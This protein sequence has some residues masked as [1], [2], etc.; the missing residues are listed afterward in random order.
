MLPTSARAC[1]LGLRGT[2]ILSCPV[3]AQ[4]HSSQ[5]AVINE[6]PAVEGDI[7]VT[8]QKRSERLLDVPLS[9][10]AVSGEA[11]QDRQINSPEQ[12]EQV[13][14]GF[15][16]QKSSF[17]AP[18]FTLRGIGFYNLSA[19]VSPAVSIYLDQ[20]PLAYSAM[21][22]GA[23]LDLERVEVL[24]G[25]QGTLFGQNSTGG[26]INYISAKPTSHPAAGFDLTYGRFNAVE[27]QGYISG[28]ITSTLKARLFARYESRDPWQ[29]GYAPNDLK[30]G[31]NPN[32]ELGRHRF[33]PA[34]CWSIG[35][36]ARPSSFT[37][38]QRAGRIIP[39]VR[40]RSSCNFFRAFRSTC[41]TK[42][43]SMLIRTRRSPCNRCRATL[44]WRDG[45]EV[46]TLRA[47]RASTSSRQIPKLILTSLR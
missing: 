38:P 45:I 11:L 12:L 42:P 35:N 16:Y 6:K 37:S 33:S 46:R 32:D 26:A 34:A 2:T 28:P 20:V 44:A 41:S 1:V 25:P 36:R 15:T 21:A 23:A 3:Q 43:F 5:Q 27:A 17:G 10:T 22:Q 47:G 30:F 29:R 19:S 40:Q 39:T 4:E 7:I 31:A 13:V 14:P 18:V 24:K 9:I 8:A